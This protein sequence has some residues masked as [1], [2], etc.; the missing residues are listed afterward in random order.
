MPREP[1]PQDELVWLQAKPQQ[2]APDNRRRGFRKTIRTFLRFACAARRDARKDLLRLNS[3]VLLL[4]EQ[5]AF[6]CHGDSAE[7]TAAVSERFANHYESRLTKPL[8]KINS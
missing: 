7:M 8:S 4:A 5:D 1:I 6:G 2:R 3:G